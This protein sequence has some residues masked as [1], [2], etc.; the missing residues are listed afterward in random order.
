MSGHNRSRDQLPC[1]P[2]G[3]G[4][5]GRR[6]RRAVSSALDLR[7]RELHTNA[8]AYAIAGEQLAAY[9]LQLIDQVHALLAAAGSAR[10]SRRAH[11][12][13]VDLASVA[14][15]APAA[16]EPFR[17]RVCMQALDAYI[18]CWG[19]AAEEDDDDGGPDGIPC[20]PR[21]PQ[22]DPDEEPCPV[23]DPPPDGL[24]VFRKA[25]A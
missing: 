5:E 3:P 23:P 22:G 16:L 21:G 9:A 18:A 14:L 13:L 8:L 11:R 2:R 12:A 17:G 24:E 1:G 10:L 25:L 4:G 15:D 6:R 20:G 19:E 7:H